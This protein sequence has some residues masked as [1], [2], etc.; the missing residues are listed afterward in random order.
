[1]EVKGQRVDLKSIKVPFLHIAAQHDHIVPAD[2]SKGIL[3]LVS[4]TDKKEIVLKGGHV[5][6]IAGGN[7]VYRLW[8]QL[9]GWL[10]ERCT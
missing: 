2:A 8:P 10:S 1:M 9:S 6:L 7:A 4:S 3:D 5:S